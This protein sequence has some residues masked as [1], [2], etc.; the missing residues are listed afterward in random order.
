MI[1][2][3]MDRY[4]EWREQSNAVRNT[5]ELWSNAPVPQQGL[6][7]EA[8]RAALDMEEHASLVYADRVNK[9]ERELALALVQERRA[10]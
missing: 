4:V 10:A 7:F 8:F 5:Y 3:L 2:E 6:A 1:D 9:I